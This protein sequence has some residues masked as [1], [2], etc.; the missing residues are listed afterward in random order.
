MTGRKVAWMLFLQRWVFL[1]ADLFCIGTTGVETASLRQV[2]S[3]W[4]VVGT[5][6]PAGASG[7]LVNAGN[8]RQQSLT[9]GVTA[10]GKQGTGR[11]Q[12]NHSPQ[13]HN[14]YPITDMAQYAQIMADH[15]QAQTMLLFKILQQIDYLGLD[16]NIK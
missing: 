15:Q 16:G 4:H 6:W 12:L 9:V 11:C 1:S 2:G 8:C 13:I 5:Q 7:N 14:R 3:R 10:T